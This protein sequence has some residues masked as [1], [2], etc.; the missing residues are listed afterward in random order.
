MA[1]KTSIKR[2]YYRKTQSKQT[3][4]LARV[5]PNLHSMKR[6]FGLPDGD[7]TLQRRYQWGR[8]ETGSS[9]NHIK[10]H[11]SKYH[12]NIF[13]I[14]I[15]KIDVKHCRFI[16]FFEYRGPYEFYSDLREELQTPLFATK[17][18]DANDA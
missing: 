12:V 13:G 17:N 2:G 7:K 10:I 4:M 15:L 11:K 6:K 14:I 18:L 1:F 16:L 8:G 5:P 3:K 9:I